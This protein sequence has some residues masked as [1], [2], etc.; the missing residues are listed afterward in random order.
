MADAAD[1]LHV[2]IGRHGDPIAWWQMSVRAV[3]ILIFGLLLVRLAGKRIFGKWGAIDMVVAVMLGS[4]FSRALTGNSP[5]L[6]TL[7]ASAVLVVMH[8]VLTW[9]A[10]RTGWLGPMLKGRPVRI[11][12]DGEPDRRVLRRHGVGEHDLE[13][14]LRQGGLTDCSEVREAWIE[15]NGDISVIKR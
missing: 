4:N 10:A 12:L 5:F 8:G 15:R 9:F 6:G 13:E 2:L 1:L 14:A 7:A 3:L 11:V